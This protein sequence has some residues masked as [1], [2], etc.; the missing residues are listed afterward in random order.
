M[1]EPGVR[2]QDEERRKAQGSRR[3][4]KQERIGKE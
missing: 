1:Q 3:K 4:E 2:R